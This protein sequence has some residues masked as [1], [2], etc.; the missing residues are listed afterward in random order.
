MRMLLALAALFVLA[1]CSGM[2]VYSVSV[3]TGHHTYYHPSHYVSYTVGYYSDSYYNGYRVY[4]THGHRYYYA[5][6][7]YAYHRHFARPVVV[8]HVHVHTSYC[9]HSVR[10]RHYTPPAV[11][12]TPPQRRPHHVA[13]PPRTRHVAPPHTRH[14]APPRTR[15]HVA[16]P[17]RTEPQV[18][19]DRQEQREDRRGQRRRQDHPE[20][21]RH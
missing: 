10:P 1:G 14:V 5:P 12:H 19:V 8:Q 4:G 21:D 17:Q 7:H 13:P 9:E 15:H 18:R 2:E 16:P 3:G 20:R 11:V 6:P